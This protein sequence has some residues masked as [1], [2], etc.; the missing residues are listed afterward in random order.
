ML[1]PKT[2][3][4]DHSQTSLNLGIK[5]FH[6]IYFDIAR[7]GIHS[8]E[9]LLKLDL[10]LSSVVVCTCTVVAAAVLVAAVVVVVGC[11]VV[12]GDAGC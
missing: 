8:V 10:L 3:I 2:V 11:T 5:L 6:S 9:M 1:L 7:Y 12:V 4:F